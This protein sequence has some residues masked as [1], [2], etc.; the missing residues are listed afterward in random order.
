MYVESDHLGTPRSVIDPARNATIWTWDAKSEAFGNDLPNQDPDLDGTSFVFNMRFPGQRYDMAS[1][2]NYNYFRDYDPSIGR[3]TESDPIGLAGGLS[4]FAYGASNPLSFFDLLGLD[5]M[6][7]HTNAVWW[8]PTSGHAWIAIYSNDGV[9][10][11]TWGAW[12]PG[13]DFTRDLKGSG[14][15]KNVEK[16]H[17]SRYNLLESTR[18]YIQLSDQQLARFREVTRQPW[19]YNEL[20]ANCASWIK[21]AVEHTIKGAKMNVDDWTVGAD[22]PRYVQGSIE[23]WKKNDAFKDNSLTNPAKFKE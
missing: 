2:L 9:L 13:H 23:I 7:I 16:V 10:K 1:G 8:G 22:T 21:Y 14:L 17:P 19:K 12:D 6:G 11:E 4:T 20:R 3:Y 15:F 5:I 18:F